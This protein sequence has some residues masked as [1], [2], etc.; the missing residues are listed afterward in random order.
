M[1][2]ALPRYLYQ[3]N[4]DL[5]PPRLSSLAESLLPQYSYVSCHTSIEQATTNVSTF[6]TPREEESISDACM[7]FQLDGDRVMTSA[8]PQLPETSLHTPWDRTDKSPFWTTRTPGRV[9]FGSV[10]GFRR[11]MSP[12]FTLGAI[13]LAALSVVRAIPT[14][15]VKARQAITALSQTQISSFKPYTHYASTAYCQPAATLA[16]NC[17]VNCQANPAFK[18]V[19]SGGDGDVTQFWFVGFDPTLDEVIVSHQGTDTSQIIPVLTDADIIM[20]PLEST[21]FPG[22][23]SSIEVHSGFAGSQSRS[24]P[25]VLSAVKTALSEFKATKVTVT[26]HSLGAAL[27]LLDAVFLPLHL[28]GV[29]VRFIGYGL[30]RVGNQAFANYVDAQQTS[31]THVNNKEDIVPI[32][33][34]RFLGFHHPSGEVH[35]EDSGEWASCPGQDNTS[36]QCIVGDVPNIFEGDEANH[37]GPYDG[38]VQHVFPLAI[39]AIQIHKSEPNSMIDLCDS[40]H[41]RFYNPKLRGGVCP[42]PEPLSNRMSIKLFP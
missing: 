41:A 42:L 14:P 18:P 24:A 28:P 8:V 4:V 22:I 11:V 35:I 30:P 26:G 20:T 29:T 2:T 1:R 40:V 39:V 36:N 27:G 19:A 10:C 23:S 12:S 32:L 38:H 3:L 25:N 21:L 5:L 13:I 33:P 9:S 34:G 7:I 16:W 31:V 17:G 6:G 15:V 37:D